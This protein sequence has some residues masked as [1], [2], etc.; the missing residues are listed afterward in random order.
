MIFS[1]SREQLMLFSPQWFL[2]CSRI[3]ES[4]VTLSANLFLPTPTI[5]GTLDSGFIN[6]FHGTS[7]I[8]VIN[9]MYN[10]DNICNIYS[11]GDRRTFSSFCII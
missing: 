10:I 4:I 11:F 7:Q 3:F 9:I 2:Y 8:R 1:V 5:G 6:V